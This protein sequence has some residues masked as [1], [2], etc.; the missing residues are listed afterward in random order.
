MRDFPDLGTV[1]PALDPKFH[2][3]RWL[4]IGEAAH[5]LGMTWGALNGR[6]QTQRQKFPTCVLPCGRRAIRESVV[7]DLLTA[8]LTD[9]PRRRATKPKA[10]GPI[11]A[12][13]PR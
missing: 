1:Q 5:M 4:S 10:S 12:A 13:A 3:E 11:H 7:I 2:G 6:C 9:R 8:Q